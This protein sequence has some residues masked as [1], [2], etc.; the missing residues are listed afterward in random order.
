MFRTKFAAFC[1][2][3]A[4]LAVG[5][6]VAFA[7]TGG[8]SSGGT[9]SGPASGSTATMGAGGTTAA[10]PHQLQ[11]TQNKGSAITRETDQKGTSGSSQPSNDASSAT[12]PGTNMSTG[13]G[14]GATPKK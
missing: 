13:S 3:V 11:D 2:A 5:P 12:G 14:N 7:Q 9:T 10:S 8:S 1:A 4:L 6:A